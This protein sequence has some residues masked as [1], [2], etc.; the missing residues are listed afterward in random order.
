MLNTDRNT[1]ILDALCKCEPII[2]AYTITPNHC[3]LATRVGLDVLSYFNIP[4]KELPVDIRLF[5]QV[6]IE[7][8]EAGCEDVQAMLDAGA[9]SLIFDK[10]FQADGW[11]GHLM[12]DLFDGD[13]LDLNFGQFN[14]PEKHLAFPPTLGFRGF[15]KTRVCPYTVNGCHVEI[16]ADPDNTH[17][18]RGDWHRDYRE[19]VG[20][21]IR[22]IKEGLN[23]KN[24]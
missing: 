6:Y 19:P 4:A 15:N 16:T 23:V 7:M 1:F 8:I 12:I 18:K 11:N 22:V 10:D 9:W 2:E 20:R 17:Y 14:R 24:L 5:N 21:I 13:L 3:I